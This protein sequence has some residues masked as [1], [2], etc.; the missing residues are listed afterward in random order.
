MAPSRA[1][2]NTRRHDENPIWFKEHAVL[3]FDDGH[4]CGTGEDLRQQMH[5]LE[6]LMLRNDERHPS[7]GGQIAQ[8]ARIGF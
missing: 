8:N 2:S 1:A 6:T 5:M 3:Y 7:V 4:S